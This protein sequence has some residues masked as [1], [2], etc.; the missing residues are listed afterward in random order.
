VPSSG[1]PTSRAIVRGKKAA[2][3]RVLPGA[4]RRDHTRG[5]RR[6]VRLVAHR[7]SWPRPIGVRNYTR[8]RENPEPVARGDRYPRVHAESVR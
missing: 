4:R 1:G 3:N 7:F 8:L 5:V 6:F 2:G